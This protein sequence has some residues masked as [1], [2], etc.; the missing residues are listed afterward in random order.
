MKLLRL[1]NTPT[2]KTHLPDSF[3]TDVPACAL[4]YGDP[5]KVVLAAEPTCKL[6]LKILKEKAELEAVK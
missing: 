6:C 1:A 3:N 2:A 5:Y 4:S